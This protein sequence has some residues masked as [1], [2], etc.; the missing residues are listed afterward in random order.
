MSVK[1]TH[2]GSLPRPDNLNEHNMEEAILNIVKMQVETGVDEVNDGEYRRLVF[3][4]NIGG[5]PGFR[6]GVYPVVA[7]AGDQYMAAVVESKIQYDPS[8]PISAKEVI[9]VKSALEKLGVKRRIKITIPSLSL[10]STSYPDPRVMPINDESLIRKLA[11]TVKKV[12]P[13]LDDYLDDMKKI[14]INEART[15]IDAGADTVQFDSPD[16]LQF[17]VYGQYLQSK[18]KER[19]KMAIEINNEVLKALPSEKLQVHSCWGNLLNTQFNTLGHYDLALPELYELKSETIGP[20]EVFD[21]IRDYDELKYFG[22]Y[23]LPK[24]KKLALGIVNVKTRNVEPVEVIRKRYEAAKK[25]VDEE[26]LIISPGCGFSSG[27]SPSGF[28]SLHSIESARRKLTN[29]VQA[30]KND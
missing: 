7:S 15:A 14:I 2:V 8:N 20:L 5:L 17:D 11:D 28:W 13:T 4:G 25:V 3:A 22:Q 9:G 30:V 24:R 1:T 18:S 21:G 27:W 26:R 16:L 12:Y 6:Q 23:S 29:M 10:M 19:L